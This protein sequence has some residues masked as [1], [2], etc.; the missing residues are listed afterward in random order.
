ME[1]AI[2]LSG[3]FRLLHNPVVAAHA[4]ATLAGIVCSKDGAAGAELFHPLLKQFAD[5]DALRANMD[6]ELRPANDKL[7][8]AMEVIDCNPDRA[9]QLADAAITASESGILDCGLLT[10]LLWRLR[11][12]SLDLADDLFPEALNFVTSV[13]APDTSLLLEIGKYLF[14]APKHLSESDREEQN[15]VFEIDQSSVANF[16]ATWISTDPDDARAISI[17]R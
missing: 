5:A 3:R 2:G 8:T 17:R 7:E 6:A 11:D 12:R 13:P 10:Q 9:A 4:E 14:K 15:E 16:T 1:W